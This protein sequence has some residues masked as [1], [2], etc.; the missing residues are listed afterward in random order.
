M[1]NDP[2]VLQSTALIERFLTHFNTTFHVSGCFMYP[3][4]WLFRVVILFTG[5]NCELHY[6]MTIHVSAGLKLFNQNFTYLWSPGSSHVIIFLNRC[7]CHLTDIDDCFPPLRPLIFGSPTCRSRI[8]IMRRQ[9]SIPLQEP[10][11]RH[12]LFCMP[13]IESKSKGWWPFINIFDGCLERS[14][15]TRSSGMWSLQCISRIKKS[16]PYFLY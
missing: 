13:W 6:T 5:C 10:D 15:M 9:F 4:N 12:H 16:I 7:I 11:R 3:W 14:H 2:H 8:P 1:W